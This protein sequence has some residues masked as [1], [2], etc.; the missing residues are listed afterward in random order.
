MYIVLL[1]L[2]IMDRNCLYN[3]CD[4]ETATGW[5]KSFLGTPLKEMAVLEEVLERTF[6]K[7][8]GEEPCS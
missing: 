6:Q 3:A 1:L 7:F 2:K 5:W 8:S 4:E